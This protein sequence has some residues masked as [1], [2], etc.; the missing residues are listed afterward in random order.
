MNPREKVSPKRGRL[1]KLK[2]SRKSSR[3]YLTSNQG[4]RMSQS[5]GKKYMRT[6]RSGR[7]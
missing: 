1:R 6:F 7:R 3:V 4:Q 2:K 5:K